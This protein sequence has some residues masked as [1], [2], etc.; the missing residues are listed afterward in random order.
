MPVMYKI[1]LDQRK[2][3]G[4]TAAVLGAIFIIAGVI[5]LIG[6]ILWLLH[7][8]QEAWKALAGEVARELGSTAA[9]EAVHDWTTDTKVYE[10]ETEQLQVS[11]CGG[12]NAVSMGGTDTV[13]SSG[14]L[15]AAFKTP[16]P[17]A[18][19]MNRNGVESEDGPRVEA[20]LGQGL[21]QDLSA[22]MDSWVRNVTVTEEALTASFH[23]KKDFKAGAR[24]ALA[25]AARVAER[26]GG[27]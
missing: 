7:K 10:W 24:Q 22:F 25:L 4:Y 12:S 26:L 14:S 8:N 5:A 13:V 9:G 18:F 6:G 2:E 23:D 19:V 15:Y 17:L 3:R 27:R 11:L 21:K 16:A 1:R 20:L